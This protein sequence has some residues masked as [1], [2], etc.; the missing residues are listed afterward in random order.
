MENAKMESTLKASIN[1]TLVSILT[2]PKQ[3]SPGLELMVSSPQL[4]SENLLYTIKPV[5]L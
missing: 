3:W 2:A 4:L 5:M 1:L